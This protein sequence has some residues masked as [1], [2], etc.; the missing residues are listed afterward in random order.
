MGGVPA[1]PSMENL[2]SLPIDAAA[3]PP[4]SNLPGLRVGEGE[5]AKHERRKEIDDALTG[6]REALA[7]QDYDSARNLVQEAE[8]IDAQSP[9]L[10]LYR[11]LLDRKLREATRD[12]TN[13]VR[14][15]RPGFAPLEIKETPWTRPTPETAAATPDTKPATE[16]TAAETSA[17]QDAIPAGLIAIAVAGVLALAAAAW[18]LL[19]RRKGTGSSAPLEPAARAI[20]PVGMAGAG[21]SM[22]AAPAAPAPPL[23]FQD[24]E[25]EPGAPPPPPPP[26]HLSHELEAVEDDAQPEDHSEFARNIAQNLET[27]PQSAPAAPAF[28]LFGNDLQQH[29]SDEPVTGY[30]DNAPTLSDNAPT[31]FENQPTLVDGMPTLVDGQDNSGRVDKSIFAAPPKMPMAPPA[32]QPKPKEPEPP[33]SAAFSDTVSF[34]DL[35]IN[36]TP[37]EP[38]VDKPAAPKAL[39]ADNQPTGEAT[40]AAPHTPPTIAKP[41]SMEGAIDLQKLFGDSPSHNAPAAQPDSEPSA[42]KPPEGI[43]LPGAGASSSQPSTPKQEDTYGGAEDTFHSQ[44]TISLGASATNIPSLG[45]LGP[46]H[47]TPSPDMASTKTMAGTNEGAYGVTPPPGTPLDE[48]SERMFREQY[49]RARKAVHDKNWRQ[50]VHY[51]SIAAAI[52]PENEEVREQLKQARNEKRRTETGGGV[53]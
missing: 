53:E 25:D 33:S 6:I 40:I 23:M 7:R 21:I 19:K 51:L 50:A 15:P 11:N 48:R 10:Q 1:P 20:A 18:F 41:V 44:D 30:L 4:Q 42:P 46:R 47:A 3:T 5:V 29:N 17:A 38:P 28:N 14:T 16:T 24:V 45:D 36:L 2:P 31:L 13:V 22:P 9:Q 26:G 12:N 43:I 39:G 52:H 37:A 32:D 35:G 49:E 27:M 8:K 34:D